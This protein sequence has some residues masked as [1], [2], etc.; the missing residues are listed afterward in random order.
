MN[1]L[2]QS[3]SSNLLPVPPSDTLSNLVPIFSNGFVSYT[4]PGGL[5]IESLK[6]RFGINGY[7]SFAPSIA[8]LD[9]TGVF[10]YVA[11]LSSLL[12]Y[13]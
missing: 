4:S 13:S 1:I 11:V 8:G 2:N 9:S 7:E 10:V 3:S 5:S 6:F 12:C